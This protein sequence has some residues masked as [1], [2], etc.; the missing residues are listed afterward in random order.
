MEDVRLEKFGRRRAGEVWK[1]EGEGKSKLFQ[2][3]PEYFFQTFRNTFSLRT[4]IPGG[5]AI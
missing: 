3:H 4:I 5:K 2:N 1:A